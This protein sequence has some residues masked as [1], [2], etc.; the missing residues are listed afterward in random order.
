MVALPT[1][2]PLLVSSSLSASPLFAAFA[3]NH[4]S[5]SSCSSQNFSPAASS[6][7][8]PSSSTTSSPRFPCMDP[9]PGRVTHSPSATVSSSFPLPMSHPFS[10]LHKSSSMPSPPE[11]HHYSSIH[12]KTATASLD[13]AIVPIKAA[14]AKI[15]G[16]DH[17]SQGRDLYAGQPQRYRLDHDPSAETKQHS[18]IDIANL[19]CTSDADRDS[20][21][22]RKPQQLAPLRAI[23]EEADDREAP[24]HT[25]P[26]GRSTSSNNSASTTRDSPYAGRVESEYAGEHR[27]S[28][29]EPLYSHRH[30]E[31]AA[32]YRTHLDRYPHSHA[33]TRPASFSIASASPSAQYP[34]SGASVSYT[35]PPRATAAGPQQRSAS[36]NTDRHR[37]YS[38]AYDQEQEQERQRRT[39]RSKSDYALHQ[40]NYGPYLNGSPPLTAAAL[41]HGYKPASSSSSSSSYS[42]AAPKRPVG[43]DSSAPLYYN[44]PHTAPPSAST[45]SPAS[46]SS[47]APYVYPRPSSSTAPS[48]SSARPMHNYAHTQK[49]EAGSSEQHF[50]QGHGPILPP[51][52]AMLSAPENKPP[53]VYGRDSTAD[54]IWQPVPRAPRV[55]PVDA[56]NEIRPYSYSSSSMLPP[57]YPPTSASSSSSASAPPV[58]MAPYSSSYSSSKMEPKPRRIYGIDAADPDI[59]QRMP[60]PASSAAY[61]QSQY[62]KPLQDIP[63][64]MEG[65]SPRRHTVGEDS[66]GYSRSYGSGAYGSQ[67]YGYSASSS[68]HYSPQEQQSRY[69]YEDRG[70][71]VSQQRPPPSHEATSSVPPSSYAPS[72]PYSR[73][74]SPSLDIKP[75]SWYQNY[76]HSVAPKPQAHPSY[77]HSDPY[78]HS[79]HT[80]RH[81]PGEYSPVNYPLPTNPTE[82]GSSSKRPSKPAQSVHPFD[83]TESKSVKSKKP[84]RIK[85]P[86]HEEDLIVMDDEFYAVKAKRKR[87]N[88][89]QLSVLNAAFERSYFPSTEERLRL[90]K[91][92]R[93]CPRTVQIWFQN[94]RQSV[95]ARSEAMEAAAGGDAGGRRDSDEPTREE[96]QGSGSSSSDGQKRSIDDEN[97]GGGDESETGR[98]QARHLLSQ[99]NGGKRRSSGMNGTITPSEAVMSALHIQL[100]G[101]SVDYFSR[102]R[103]ATIAKMEQSEQQKQKQQQQQQQQ[104]EKEEPFKGEE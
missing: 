79:S 67:A 46:S 98:R 4:S 80:Q 71:K 56:P 74:Q 13:Q 64:S 44:P 93:M 86:G 51:P 50:R 89:S 60:P 30:T 15:Q 96:R 57:P 76:A 24:A 47:S 25:S 53:R 54:E 23:T 49:S 59:P 43:I 19:L 18:R 83:T 41:P 77:Q 22:D 34:A 10:K 91:Q 104:Q 70:W 88:A 6:P 16:H 39:D 68:R 99:E 66:A 87:A 97:G 38:H 31:G 33:G 84:K 27:A 58:P 12:V 29:R 28:D 1:S 63:D 65:E 8:S 26:Y 32:S 42:S 14:L 103:R 81:Q 61:R 17:P 37:D 45:S 62:S 9:V 11:Q 3:R 94:K 85:N 72:R 40:Q 90:S 48:S 101:R 102:K 2:T 21:Y 75:P 20:D 36:W 82:H 100:D 78:Y 35:E 5:H 52:A 73:P 55:V 69:D 7:S 92:C 95:K